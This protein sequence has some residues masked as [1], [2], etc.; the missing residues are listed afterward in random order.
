MTRR[1]TLQL[2]PRP[3][4]RPLE[5]PRISH[6]EV[7]AA[8]DADWR[9]QLRCATCFWPM[10]IVALTQHSRAVQVGLPG[11]FKWITY[12]WEPETYCG[13]CWSSHRFEGTVGDSIPILM[14]RTLH[15]SCVRLPRC[16]NRHF[17][18]YCPD[19]VSRLDV[20]IQRH[21]VIPSL[22]RAEMVCVHCDKWLQPT[23]VWTT[24][25]SGKLKAE[26]RCGGC[27]LIYSFEG[28]PSTAPNQR[29]YTNHYG[30]RR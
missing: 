21:P 15:N 20:P 24:G 13:R 19:H 1:F 14:A 26:A 11:V 23:D 17:Y 25:P 2:V 4:E 22:W 27:R 9:D 18:H 30:R 28:N 7:P 29:S 16:A 8:W 10:P 6:P 12:N 5:F 3:E